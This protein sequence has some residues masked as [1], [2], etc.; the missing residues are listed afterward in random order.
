MGTLYAHASA[1]TF[2]KNRLVAPS[3]HVHCMV[4]ILIPSLSVPIYD[5][6]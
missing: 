6:L 2:P 5:G 3:F 4:L 1:P